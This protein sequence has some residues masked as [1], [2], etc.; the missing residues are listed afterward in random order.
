MD[1]G[2]RKLIFDLISQ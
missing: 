2:G 1:S